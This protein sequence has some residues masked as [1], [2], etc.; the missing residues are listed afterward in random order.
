VVRANTTASGSTECLLSFW[1]E[2][3]MARGSGRDVSRYIFHVAGH[4]ELIER[5]AELDR[6]HRLSR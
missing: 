6:E 4:S 5:I 2:P 3:F 1:G